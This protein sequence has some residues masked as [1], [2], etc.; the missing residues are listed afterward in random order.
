MNGL[1]PGY[2]RRP[3]KFPALLLTTCLHRQRQ[4]KAAV[5]VLRLAG[6][7]V[8]L[9]SPGDGELESDSNGHASVLATSLKACPNNQTTARVRGTNA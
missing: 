1:G 4:P 8:L 5:S 3:D 9:H 6:P 7:F 2:C